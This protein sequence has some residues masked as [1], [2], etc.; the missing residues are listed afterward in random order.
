MRTYRTEGKAFKRAQALM[1][2]LGVWTSVV[3]MSGHCYRLS[4]DPVE[5]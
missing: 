4:Y 3:R 2:R 1:N 5:V